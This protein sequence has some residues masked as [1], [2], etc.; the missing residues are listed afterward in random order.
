MANCLRLLI[1]CALVGIPSAAHGDVITDWNTAALNAIRVNRTSPPVASRA[2]AILHASMY[3]AVNGISRS[4]EPYL[5]QSAVPSSASKEAAAAAAGRRVLMTL[6][7]REPHRFDQLYLVT[8]AGIPDGPHKRAG[9]AWG[10]YVAA[11]ILAARDNDGSAAIVPVPEGGAP[12]AWVA[13]PL[14]YL[15]PQWA[16]VRPF[17]MPASDSF[18]PGGPPALDSA[19]YVADFNEVKTLGAAVGSTRTVD[20]TLIALFWA[21]GAGTETPPGHWNSIA[22]VAAGM[23]GNTLEQDARLF[24]LLNM[25]M[26]DAAICAWDAKYQYMFWRP[27][28]AV[29]NA[30]DDGNPATA[31]DAAW[32]SLIATPP[33]PEYVSGHSAFSGAAATILTR[34]FASDEVTF[35]TRSDFL[36]G[37]VWQ[38]TSFSA[39]ARQAAESRVYGGIHFRSASEDGLAGG[40]G[41][42]NWV[43]DF[44]LQP[45]GNRS[46]K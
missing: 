23:S 30:D 19:R 32:Q 15:L 2:L 38:F 12:G 9:I 31:S 41:I 37:V 42:G 45:K 39:A 1:A 21:D 7:S 20:Q 27:I 26:A 13:M 17:T 35:S 4:H 36:P 29:R 43:A 34:F 5:V 3:D 25:A 14:P 22:Q 40:I 24:A 33:F 8:L 6:F 28:T 16:F 44:F 46:R 18:R 11:Q 10:E